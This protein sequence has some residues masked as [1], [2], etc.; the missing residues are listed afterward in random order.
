MPASY[1]NAWYL[2]SLYIDVFDFSEYQSLPELPDLLCIGGQKIGPPARQ[3]HVP[4]LVNLST[5]FSNLLDLAIQQFQISKS[6]TLRVWHNQSSEPVTGSH[7]TQ[8]TGAKSVSGV[9]SYFKLSRLPTVSFALGIQKFQLLLLGESKSISPNW[10]VFLAQVPY[11]TA[12]FWKFLSKCLSR[13]GPTLRG[14][15]VILLPRCDKQ[16]MTPHMKVDEHSTSR[17]N[18]FLSV[19]RYIKTKS[20]HGLEND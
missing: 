17:N 18:E 13:A 8:W 12:H 15:S 19:S 14:C 11:Y 16:D 2:E 10:S 7:P 6:V 4:C 1:V 5:T 3:Y 20:R 9:P